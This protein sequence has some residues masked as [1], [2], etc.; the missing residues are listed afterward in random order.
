MDQNPTS[1][2]STP[3]ASE[4]PSRR[5]I[6]A[7]LAAV[8]LVLIAGGYI[9]YRLWDDGPFSR[10][11]QGEVMLASDS[12]PIAPAQV[13]EDGALVPLRVEGQGTAH[14]ID[15]ARTATHGYYLIADQGLDTVQLYRNDLADE[16]AGLAQ[17]TSSPSLKFD[18]SFDELSGQVAYTEA[19]TAGPTR[20]RVW[21]PATTT[22]HDLGAGSRPTLLP[23]GFFAVF[24]QDGKLVSVNVATGE[25]HELLE[26]PSRAFAVDPENMRVALYNPQT[27]SVQQFSIARQT[28][29]SYE[30]ST[31]LT[32]VPQELVWHD[33]QMLALIDRSERLVLTTLEGEELLSVPLRVGAFANLGINL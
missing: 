11:P 12:L 7:V 5:K 22:V 8:V 31:P 28:S 17:L 23:G 15:A 1:P 30:S 2:F 24:V 21:G 27:A 32:S 6:V 33:G 19:S 18:M 26:L 10:A 9:A 29:A 13:L 16:S 20:V 25:R 14:L 4:P 3:T